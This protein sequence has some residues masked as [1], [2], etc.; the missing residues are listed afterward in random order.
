VPPHVHWENLIYLPTL[1]CGWVFWVL[2]AYVLLVLVML[3]FFKGCSI[4]EAEESEAQQCQTKPK[5]LK[6]ATLKPRYL[7]GG[8]AVSARK[9]TAALSDTSGQ[10][11]SG[12]KARPRNSK[13]ARSSN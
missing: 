3:L 8:H 6:H 13:T 1:R 11:S 5:K 7:H 2:A 10:Y 9:S 12:T 4:R